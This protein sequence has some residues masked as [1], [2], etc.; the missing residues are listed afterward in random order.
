MGAS[1]SPLGALPRRICLLRHRQGDKTTISKMGRLGRQPTDSGQAPG[2]GDRTRHGMA[3]LHATLPAS[4]PNARQPLLVPPLSL[5]RKPSVCSY[6]YVDLLSTRALLTRRPYY[7]GPACPLCRILHTGE[8]PPLPAQH[9]FTHSH[10]LPL[11]HHQTFLSKPASLAVL[12]EQVFKTFV[13]M[14]DEGWDVRVGERWTHTEVGHLF[15][16]PCPSPPGR[17]GTCRPGQ[18]L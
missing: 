15:P 18:C 14:T 7:Y 3:W 6:I 16:S 4:L 1:R 2:A 13:T 17:V 8:Y 5:W 11:P 9:T 10:L 12:P